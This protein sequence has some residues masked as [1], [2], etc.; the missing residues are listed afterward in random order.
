MSA[1]VP[2]FDDID[3]R[4]MGLLQNDARRSNKELAAELGVAQSTCLERV[5]SLR[6]LGVIKGFHAEV[7][8]E[9]LGRSVVA[10]VTV[11]LSPKNSDSVREFRAQMLEQPEVLVVYATSGEDDFMVELAVG[12]VH[13]LF[14]FLLEHV[15]SRPDVGYTRTTLVYEYTRKVVVEPLRPAAP[16]QIRRRA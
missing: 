2:N 9:A 16:Q 3:V 11:R 14:D 8:L 1:D 10:L 13:Q 6:S 15:T 12:S 5:R 4:L 7:D